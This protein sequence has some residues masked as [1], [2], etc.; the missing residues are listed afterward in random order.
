VKSQG[1]ERLLW[2][3]VL[4]AALLWLTACAPRAVKPPAGGIGGRQLVTQLAETNHGLA[5]VKGIGS[6]TLWTQ[7]SSH[8]ARVAW[9]AAAPSRI[10]L[11][12]FGLLGQGQLSLAADGRHIT[13]HSL[14]DG[15]FYSRSADDPSLEK[16]V[17]F[18]INV[19]DLVTFLMGRVPLRDTSRTRVLPD[20]GEGGGII[21]CLDRFW[22]G[23]RE[24]I[25]FDGD[26]R[27]RQVEFFSVTGELLYRAE[28][29]AAD[30]I[31]GFSLPRQLLLTG[32]GNR[33]LRLTVER[34]WANP[35]LSPGVFTLTEN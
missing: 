35:A 17:G 2:V 24:K 33:R 27:V 34:S 7:G 4:L 11:H 3:P 15:R 14:S 5:A 10:R 22:S 1:R 19:S 30:M 29:G 23:S 31:D 16:V 26:G 13:Y 9:I 12:V 6:F 21:L 28:M 20:D 32:R 18:P 8:S 25:T